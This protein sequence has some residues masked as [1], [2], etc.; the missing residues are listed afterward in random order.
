MPKLAFSLVKITIGDPLVALSMGSIDFSQDPDPDF[1][2][3]THQENQSEVHELY[4]DKYIMDSGTGLAYQGIRSQDD[5]GEYVWTH[6]FGYYSYTLAI[7]E[8]TN[9]SDNKYYA[10]LPAFDSEE[11]SYFEITAPENPFL[12]SSGS[13]KE[14][15][16]DTTFDRHNLFNKEDLRM[17][18]YGGNGEDILEKYDTYGDALPN[19]YDDAET[20]VKNA[21]TE[22]D[23]DSDING[24]SLALGVASVA[25][26]AITT[27]SAV[28]VLGTAAGVGGLL[29]T[30]G[31]VTEEGDVDSQYGKQ[32][33]CPSFG[34]EVTHSDGNETLV[35]SYCKF[36]VTV[37]VD[38]SLTLYA[39]SRYGLVDNVPSDY[40]EM[41]FVDDFTC[42]Y[43]SK[44]E[45]PAIPEKPQNE[46][47][48]YPTFS[49]MDSQPDESIKGVYDNSCKTGTE[50]FW[51]TT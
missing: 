12:D 9:K 17:E 23:W 7:T 8:G 20:R 41:Q 2:E 36:E 25:A 11:S 32:G 15:Y 43:W 49:A 39:N 14:K 42:N 4:N 38:T 13:Q 48:E 27:A 29:T 31:R 18:S 37:P 5:A 28:G 1:E 24:P 6:Q 40:S 21:E 44:I 10:T 26:G 16:L 22:P 35:M 34:G 30:I 51:D 50:G 46:I 3:Q 47:E 19:S 33:N 45:I